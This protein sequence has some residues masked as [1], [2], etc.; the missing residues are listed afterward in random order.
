M[1]P[2]RLS[3]DADCLSEIGVVLMHQRCGKLKK[4]ERKVQTITGVTKRKFVPIQIERTVFT[5]KG[6]KY[7]P[8]EEVLADWV[9][10]TL[11]YPDGK[12][13]SSTQLRLL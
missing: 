13:L 7:L 8:V 12:C 4:V 10:G 2:F 11:Y 9:T 3:D 1:K 5:K 6:W